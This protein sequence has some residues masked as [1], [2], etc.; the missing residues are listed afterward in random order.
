MKNHNFFILV[1]FLLMG[2]LVA[3]PTFSNIPSPLTTGAMFDEIYTNLGNKYALADLNIMAQRPLGETYTIA[4]VP[5]ESCI[6]GYFHLY[7]TGTLFT[8]GTQSAQAQA[9]VCEVFTSLSNFISSPLSTLGNT[10]E[11]NILIGNSNSLAGQGELFYS[12]PNNPQSLSQ[13]VIDN[14]IYKTITSGVD[15]YSTLPITIFNTTQANNFYHGALRINPGYN[16]NTNMATTSI[17]S[18]EYDLYSVVL[19]EAVH[20]L[21]FISLI[22]CD[23]SSALGFI[24]QFSRYD[25]FLKSYNNTPLLTAITPSNCS[26]FN[27]AFNSS[28]LTPSV[29]LSQTNCIPSPAFQNV[30]TCSVAAKYVSSNATSTVYTPSYFEPGSSLSHFE[31]MCTYGSFTSVC[32]PTPSSPGYNDLY[33]LM[34]NSGDT[35]DCYVKRY[36]RE[37]EKNVLCDLGYTTNTVITSSA[38]GASHT[39]AANCVPTATIV[40]VNDGYSLSGGYTF[41]TGTSSIVI[42]LNS[43]L[44]ND[45]PNSGL[46]V[47]C[48]SSVYAN[49]TFTLGASTLTVNALQG[50]GV[51]TLKYYPQNAQGDFGNATYIFIKFMPGGCNPGNSCNLVQNGGFE[52][53]VSGPSCGLVI[54]GGTGNL[55]TLSCWDNY[56]GGH[57][58][59]NTTCTGPNL[60]FNLGVNTLNILPPV[61]SFNGGGSAIS[62]P[63]YNA[64]TGSIRNTLSSPLVPG[65]PYQLSFWGQN[66]SSVTPSLGTS[67][68]PNA[69]PAIL[70]IASYTDAGNTPFANFPANLDVLTQ[71]TINAG[72]VW[73]QYTYTFVYSGSLAPGTAIIIGLNSAVSA[74]IPVNSIMHCFL[75]EVNLVALPSP[76]FSIPTLSCGNE[77][78]ANLANY[79]ST[80]ST[81]DFSGTGVNYNFINYSFNSPPSL[82]PGSYPIAFNY[83]NTGCTNT[84]WQVVEVNTPVSLYA[85]GPSSY[86]ANAGGGTTVNVT[87]NVSTSSLN[88]T[89]QPGGLTGSLQTISPTIT[90]I[91]TITSV[92]NASTTNICPATQTLLVNVSNNCC[93][94]LSIA[95]F[96]QTSLNSNTLL[97][98]PMIINYDF[99]VTPSVQ[100]TM[101]GDFIMADGVK[102][103]VAG[104]GDLDASFVHMRSCSTEMWEGIEVQDGGFLSLF[105]DSNGDNLIEDAVTA[106]DVSNSTTTTATNFIIINN[107]IFNKNH[108]DIKLHNYQRSAN[109]YSNAFIIHS[110]VFTCRNY[111]YTGY[112]WP[113]TTGAAS[114]NLRTVNNAT[115]GLIPPYDLLSAPTTT[116]KSPYAGQTS[117]VAILITSVG[118]TSGN[119]FYGITIG[120]TS[121]PTL[122]NLFD[123]H[124]RSI[125]CTNSNVILANNVFQNTLFTGSGSGLTGPGDGS[126]VYSAATGVMSNRLEMGASSF[127]LGNRFWNC[128][129]GV[130]GRNVYVFN[131]EKAIFRSTQS[132]TNTAFGPGNTGI[133]LATNRAQ[134]QVLRNEFTNINAGLTIPLSPGSQTLSASCGTCPVPFGIYAANMSIQQNTFFAGPSGTDYM[135][136]AINITAPNQASW[137]VNN[138]TNITPFTLGIIASNNTINEA[139]RGITINGVQGWRTLMEANSI[140]L[141][142]DNVFSMAQRGIELNAFNATPNSYAH[143]K[144]N[145]LYS[146][147]AN[148]YTQTLTSLIYC[149]DNMGPT[150]GQPSV[151]CNDVHD[152]YNGFVFDSQNQGTSWYGNDMENL[153]R[154]ML[155]TYSAVIGAQGS[156]TTG[157]GNRWPGSNWNGTNYGIYTYSSNAVFSPLYVA[158]TTTPTFPPNLFGVPNS[159]SFATYTPNVTSGGASY[160]CFA[161][162]NK[163]NNA[164][165]PNLTYYADDESFF[166][167]LSAL[168]NFLH[169]NDS[170]KNSSSSLLNFYNNLS[171]SSLDNFAQAED[172]LMAGDLSGAYSLFSSVSPTNAVESNYLT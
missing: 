10:V 57:Y 131:I 156:A 165:I 157:I 64:F 125:H 97:F 75:D 113:Q 61:I 107:T 115:T 33:F 35:D 4:T 98:G 133:S 144:G 170:I 79:T 171:G 154:G 94:T 36:L 100:L 139:Y 151:T 28:L 5:T 145:E 136:R 7:F 140:T 67:V 138:V 13:G 70:T 17:A 8:S 51:I 91:Y 116:L 19:H 124:N 105:G 22:D 23:G 114:L 118:I 84:L 167:A 63:A 27:L 134:Y 132:T 56:S 128:H 106:V 120:S 21:G 130:Q 166:I 163:A 62:I 29:V 127:D 149:G 153:A 34:S 152:S 104:G 89:W 95:G 59:F 142:E 83:T 92:G 15:P 129:R 47:S 24:E 169:Q 66:P 109:T 155:L 122:F 123:S 40:G 126:A 50:A 65:Q 87:P 82:S 54:T 45:L 9:V 44:A 108:I 141:K 137:T 53:L 103:T 60:G 88:I 162:T 3:Q 30:T 48:V 93:G 16:W 72:S 77:S 148:T 78:I 90:T 164:I 160:N 101:T 143:I 43:I 52:N 14:L 11:I 161:P 74:S 73:S 55:T 146:V 58:I 26:S 2:K 12:T 6:A 117:S 31:D 99:T 37:E 110:N 158:G 46:S 112:T 1:I 69:A 172:Y 20:L 86:C 41:T 80:V 38:A 168:Y 96:T 121:S 85:T 147:G 25:R 76:T 49:A 81:G 135:N 71:F 18:N 39:Y 68:N 111:T 42:S 119:N 159:S 150:L 32:T 102:I